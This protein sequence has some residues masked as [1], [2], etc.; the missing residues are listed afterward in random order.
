M[1]GL[2]RCLSLHRCL[3]L[4]RCLSLLA[5]SAACAAGGLLLLQGECHM[6]TA[7]L[8]WGVLEVALCTILLWW[9]VL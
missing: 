1:R 4:L 3:N 9:G 7:A 8:L 2:H 5:A 6:G